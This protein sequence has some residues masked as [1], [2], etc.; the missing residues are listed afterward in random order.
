MHAARLRTVWDKEKGK[1]EVSYT[2]GKDVL[3]GTFEA[4]L[5]IPHFSG[6][7]VNGRDS[8]LPSGIQR[9][10]SLAQ[11]GKTGVLTKNG[12]TLIT[13][14]GVTAYLRTD[15]STGTWMAL[16]PTPTPTKWSLTVPGQVTI[17]AEG[18]LGL[19]RVTVR[20]KDGAL[21]I[22]YA[23]GDGE[24]NLASA[25]QVGGLGNAPKVIRNG[26][27]VL[28]KLASKVVNGKTIHIVP[29]P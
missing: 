7:R 19:A 3:E 5:S 21:W 18:R 6:C 1:L 20:P 12:A 16:N 22:D 23:V 11:Q 29:L 24:K 14:P 9:D 25:L 28:G 26:K 17:A 27:A 2:S 13:D 15:P 4:A 8:D 10:T